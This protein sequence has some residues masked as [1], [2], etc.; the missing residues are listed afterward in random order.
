MLA[1]TATYASFIAEDKISSAA[2]I[3]SEI[4]ISTLLITYYIAN[5]GLETTTR[6]TQSRI[7]RAITS[8]IIR[9]TTLTTRKTT[10]MNINLKA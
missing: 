1:F 2:A 8:L 7:V 6:I 4:D 5:K 3:C 10:K 9:R